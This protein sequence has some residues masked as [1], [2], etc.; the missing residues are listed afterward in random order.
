V[1]PA[2]P[3]RGRAPHDRDRRK[4]LYAQVQR[5]VAQDLP[6]LS[7][8]YPDNVCLHSRRV[9]NVVLTPAGDYDF[10]AGIKIDA[11]QKR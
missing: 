7:L 11:D 8:W 2:R 1:L 6:Y 9:S 4:L 3:A 5:I 10:V